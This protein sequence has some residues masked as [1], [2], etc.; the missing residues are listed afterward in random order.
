MML[1]ERDLR[2]LSFLVAHKAAPIDV[3]AARFFS[4]APDGTKNGNPARAARVRIDALAA[5]GLLSTTSRRLRT[6]GPIVLVTPTADGAAAIGARPPASLPTRN[7]DHHTATHRAVL[8]VRGQLEDLGY[9]VNDE[10]LDAQVRAA[11]LGGKATQKSQ[12][13][14]CFADAVLQVT[15][16][17]GQKRVIAIEYVTARYTFDMLRTKAAD[18]ATYD[19]VYWLSDTPQTAAR[20]H[21][22]VGQVA[23]CL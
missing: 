14:P 15:D 3:L 10:Q 1:T 7:L 2:L 13:F 23:S 20:I 17:S 19:A 4:V 8:K 9:V 18:F 22:T 5:A 11:A 21:A 16:P 12:A 6:Q